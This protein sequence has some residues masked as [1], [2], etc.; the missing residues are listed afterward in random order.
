MF[1][2]GLKTKHNFL[3][4][5]VMILMVLWIFKVFNLLIEVTSEWSSSDQVQ[6]EH[7]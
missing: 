7:C 3:C 5:A 2:S 6:I 4:L 1:W